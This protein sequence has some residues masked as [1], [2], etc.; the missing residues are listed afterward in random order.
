MRSNVGLH[1]QFSKR[2]YYMSSDVFLNLNEAFMMLAVKVNLYNAPGAGST[3]SNCSEKKIE[4]AQLE[5][6]LRKFCKI[7]INISLFF[8]RFCSKKPLNNERQVLSIMLSSISMMHWSPLQPFA[9]LNR[10]HQSILRTLRSE[11]NARRN[12]YIQK[13]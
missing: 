8:T 9:L 4:V 7:F 3:D 13:E 11:E 5:S 6:L 10:D 1:P 12:G 2:C